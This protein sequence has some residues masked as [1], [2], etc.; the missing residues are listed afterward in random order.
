MFDPMNDERCYRT[1]VKWRK[2]H[3]WFVTKPR[4]IG[5]VIY[6]LWFCVTWPMRWWLFDGNQIGPK[7][8]STEAIR[9]A[10]IFILCLVK[11]PHEKLLE[12]VL[13][14]FRFQLLANSIAI[15]NRMHTLSILSIQI[16]VI[17]RRRVNEKKSKYTEKEL[18]DCVWSKC[19]SQH[20]FYGKLNLIAIY[21]FS[22]HPKIK[23]QH[24]RDRKMKQHFLMLPS[25]HLD[26]M[27][28]SPII[29][30]FE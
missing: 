22:F 5:F 19:I 1:L 28:T 4:E 3:I 16:E 15:A 14:L 23:Q 7:T 13:F 20:L 24:I 26:T 18:R 29:L 17:Y 9:H 8:H 2:W 6:D 12:T 27:Q 25:S 11:A 21:R 10:A 30:F